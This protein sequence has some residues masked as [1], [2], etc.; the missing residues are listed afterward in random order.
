MVHRKLCLKVTGKK[1]KADWV[2]SLHV[3]YSLLDP[4]KWLYSQP[5][6]VVC[7]LRCSTS[8]LTNPLMLGVI[9]QKNTEVTKSITNCSEENMQMQCKNMNRYAS[10]LVRLNYSGIILYE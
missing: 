1:E 6:V 10:S 5:L 4:G 2:S 7:L 9:F 3:Q 8:T